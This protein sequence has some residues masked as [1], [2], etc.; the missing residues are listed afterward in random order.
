MQIIS[1]YACLHYIIACYRLDNS[2]FLPNATGAVAGGIVAAIVIA[3]LLVVG[4]I[5]IVVFTRL[6][7]LLLSPL[8][9]IVFTKA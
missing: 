2:G 4:I 7:N 9:I 3:V 6:I 5:L 1:C 8:F